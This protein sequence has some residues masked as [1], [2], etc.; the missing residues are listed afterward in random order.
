MFKL[1]M[2]SVLIIIGFVF[3]LFGFFMNQGSSIDIQIHDTYIVTGFATTVRSIGV[4]IVLNGLV[5]SLFDKINFRFNRRFKYFGITLLLISL[6]IVLVSFI[7]LYEPIN[8]GSFY[9][10]LDQ[11]TISFLMI[12]AGLF[13]L[14][15]S[16]FM[17]F[18]I[19]VY[20]G[21]KNILSQY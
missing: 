14:L 12:F 17:P 2:D 16:L 4:L 1:N 19:W 5:Y 13:T 18:F 8:A 10:R 7:A 11:G 3:L 15:L 9:L 6:F 21:I 20:F